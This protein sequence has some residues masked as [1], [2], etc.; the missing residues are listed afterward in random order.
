MADV[1]K[2]IEISYKADLKD[3]L[4][5]LKK[6]PNMTKEEAQKMVGVLRT[7][8]NKSTRAAEKAARAHKKEFKKIEKSAQRAEK[9]IFGMNKATVGNI[10]NIGIA[11]GAAAVGLGFFVQEIADMS[12]QLVDASTATGIS[13][14]ILGGLRIAAEGAG[15]QFENL[16]RSLI[17]LPKTMKDA[18]A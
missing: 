14:E 4:K 13:V 16:E 12:N 11:A 5:N 15:L 7:E 17:K 2:S 8:L 9:A 6:I 10:K 18:Q 3:L 1:N